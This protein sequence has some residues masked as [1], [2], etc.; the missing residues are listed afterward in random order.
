MK[1]LLVLTLALLTMLTLAACGGETAKAPENLDL[2]AVYQGILD[3]QGD[4]KDSLTMLP[5]PEDSVFVAS[6]YPGLSDIACKQKVCYL[7]PVS[8]WATE[9]LL[10][11]VEKAE[12]VETV[13]EIFQKRIDAAK[14][15]TDYAETAAQWENAQVQSAGNYV[16]MIVLTEEYTIPENVFAAD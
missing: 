13:K 14:S 10:V 15:D 3:A 4:K 9:V 5:E 16:G 7:A 8:G 6:S 2:E 1:K 11:E 12:D